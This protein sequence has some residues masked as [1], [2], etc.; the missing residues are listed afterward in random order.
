MPLTM[1][2][3][4]LLIVVLAT[5]VLARPY[6]QTAVD[7]GVRRRRA[8][9]LAYQSR[10]AE[11]EADV[12]SAVVDADSA[13]E[14]RDETAARLLSD[15]DV[16]A[17]AP[18][19]SFAPRRWGVVLAL[20]LVVAAGTLAGYFLDG[21]WQT[22]ELIE[23]SREDP[24]AAQQQ[25]LQSMVTKLQAQVRRE[26]DDAEGWAMLGRSQALLGE[27]GKSAQAYAE[28][29]S[30]SGG[31]PRPDWLVGEGEALAMSRDQQ[32]GA[33]RKLFDRA[34]QLDPGH[35]RALWYAGLTAAQEE[36]YGAALDHWLMLRKQ[37]LPA[38]LAA[39]L[40]ERL[41]Q[42]AQLSGRKLPASEPTGP[43]AAAD[44]L[45]LNVTVDVAPALRA[46]F[47]GDGVLFIFARAASGPPMP[48][49]VQRVEGAKLPMQVKLD[50]SLAMMPDLKLSRFDAWTVTARYSRSGVATP[51]SG[52]L[53]G[54]LSVTREQAAA[55]LNLL[56]DHVVP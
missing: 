10:L 20:L 8:N 24:R 7:T 3:G 11:I 37:E 12:A 6:L 25:M 50:D 1:L 44:V 55:P 26:P 51:S 40:D 47:A 49:A 19:A 32:L 46:Q 15:T 13:G 28:A 5:L 16:P 31:Q 48:L 53:E 18:A 4:M 30:R 2:L 41:P 45:A 23:I 35:G 33:A 38:D 54:T 36:D 27:Y 14:L 21:S 17:E 39:V 52:D 43:A 22:R 56:I 9:V 29:N 42:L 34:L